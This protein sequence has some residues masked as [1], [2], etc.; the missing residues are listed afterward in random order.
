MLRL[1]ISQGVQLEVY[2]WTLCLV[3]FAKLSQFPF[4]YSLRIPPVCIFGYPISPEGV[5]GP[6]PTLPEPHAF[7]Y[8]TMHKL[9]CRHRAK[10]F[11][12]N[13][14]KS[15]P[16]LCGPFDCFYTAE[17]ASA[18]KDHRHR[19]PVMWSGGRTLLSAT[20][21]AIA[22]LLP[23][24]APRRSQG[25][26]KS[27]IHKKADVLLWWHSNR[28]LECSDRYQTRYACCPATKQAYFTWV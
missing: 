23:W 24:R 7:P 19:V 20:L 4:R 15:K 17:K 8:G 3:S 21:R 11:W 28:Y 10:Y 13:C 6:P 16:S 27:R 25:S 9:L 26:K 5:I 14:Q 18:L 1:F 22:D 12:A 2:I